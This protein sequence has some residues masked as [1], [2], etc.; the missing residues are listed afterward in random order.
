MNFF[1]CIDNLKPFL[2][3]FL[4]TFYCQFYHFKHSFL[5]IFLF[6]FICVHWVENSQESLGEDLQVEFL[7]TTKAKVFIK[8]LNFF[9]CQAKSF[10]FQIWIK[11]LNKDL[12]AMQW[13]HIFEQLTRIY[14]VDSRLRTIYFQLT[15]DD[16]LHKDNKAFRNIG[17]HNHFL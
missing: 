16:S 17:F 12:S 7:E 8:K 2:F 1:Y 10:P 11:I 5:W 14:T 15:L 3:Y 9:F 4:V 13:I 6:L